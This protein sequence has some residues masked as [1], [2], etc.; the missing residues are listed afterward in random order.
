[1]SDQQIRL[2]TRTPS[3]I[4]NT[5]DNIL[6]CM[7]SDFILSWHRDEY[8]Q[9]CKGSDQ[10]DVRQQLCKHG[11]ARNNRRGSVFYVIRSTPSGGSGPM[12]SQSYTWHMFSVWSA[13]CNNRGAVFLR[14]VRAERIWEN[15]GM[16]IDF[17]WIP[18]FQGNSSVARR[19]IRRLSVWRYVCCSTSILGVCNL[20]RLLQFLCHKSVARKRIVKASGNRLRRI[21]WSDY[22]LCKSAI[23]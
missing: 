19:R 16:G 7:R 11:P 21:L 8:D 22:K 18:K 20:V 17:T 3:I 2:P 23:V 15:T 10:R 5:R 4:T 6:P 9:Y 14:V 13:P 12:N 1:V